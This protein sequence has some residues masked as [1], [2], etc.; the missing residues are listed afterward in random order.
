PHHICP[1]CGYYR[2]REVVKV[3]VSEGRA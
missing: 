3:S 2:G 1:H